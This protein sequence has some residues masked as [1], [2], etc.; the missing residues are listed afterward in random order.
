MDNNI[1]IMDA[2]LDHKISHYKSDDNDF[3]A[4]K[5][6]TVTITLNEYRQLIS[7]K[8][9]KE[10]DLDKIR[11]EKWKVQ[12]ELN[13]AKAKIERLYAQLYEKQEEPAN[14]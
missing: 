8:A 7:A 4:D 5:E 2:L 11:S 13:E 1:K 14:D 3:V 9:T 6:L 10:H 12:E